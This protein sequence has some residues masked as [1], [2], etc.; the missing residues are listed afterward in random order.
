MV[1]S[2]H[3]L[4]PEPM[5]AQALRGARHNAVLRAHAEWPRA[6]RADAGIARN[7]PLCEVRST[8]PAATARTRPA[9]CRPGPVSTSCAKRLAPEIEQ[10][11]VEEVRKVRAE[12]RLRGAS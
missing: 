7:S 9:R 3:G 2:G 12:R 8:S 11:I 1:F 4:V 5:P 6:L 10:E